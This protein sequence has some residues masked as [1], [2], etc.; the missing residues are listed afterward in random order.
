VA[1]VSVADL[2]AKR[3]I[4]SPLTRGV[5]SPQCQYRRR[6]YHITTLHA[7]AVGRFYTDRAHTSEDDKIHPGVCTGVR[8][9][10]GRPRPRYP[11]F[12]CSYAST[13]CYFR[14][15]AP[16]GRTVTPL[17][18]IDLHRQV[19]LAIHKAAS[20]DGRFEKFSPVIYLVTPGRPGCDLRQGMFVTL[21][22]LASIKSC[23]LP[24]GGV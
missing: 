22:H 19:V 6:G 4:I 9:C 12:K 13:P 23:R 16:Q 3:D 18:W 15:Q 2:L 21:L 14:S 5:L 24:E 17:S 20:A 7:A 8:S 11:M 10:S 1:F